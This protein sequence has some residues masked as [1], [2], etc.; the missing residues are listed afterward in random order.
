MKIGLLIIYGL[1]LAAVIIA[2]F[3][4][5]DVLNFKV[6]I[7]GLIAQI[8]TNDLLPQLGTFVKDNVATIVSVAI[9]TVIGLVTYVKYKAELTAKKELLELQTELQ[10]K[11]LNAEAL[12]ENTKVTASNTISNLESELAGFKGDTTAEELQKRLQSTL[13]LTEAQ[14]IQI[15]ELQKAPAQL[16]EQL[17]AKSGGQTLE[18]AGQQYKIIE[19]VIINTK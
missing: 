13:S 11:T 8:P 7:N 19:K 3:Y 5:F 6:F 16:A 1:L 2:L 4:F 14:K 17:W 18:I 12:V 15:E 10:A 9:P